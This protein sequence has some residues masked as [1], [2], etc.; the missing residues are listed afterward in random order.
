L[1]SQ[2]PHPNREEIKRGIAGNLCRCTGYQHVV[3]AIETASQ[4]VTV[5]EK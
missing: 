1:L 2:N 4:H 5:N 3:D